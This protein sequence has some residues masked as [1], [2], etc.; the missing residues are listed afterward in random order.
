VLAAGLVPPVVRLSLSPPELDRALMLR[1]LVFAAPMIAFVF[2]QYGMRAVDIV[3]L[4][5]YEP[6]HEVG[7]YAVAYQSYLMLMQVATSATIVLTPLFV[8]LRGAGRT[9]ALA[10]YFRRTVPLLSLAWTVIVAI[11]LPLAPLA[12]PVVFGEDFARASDPIVLLS[13]ALVVQAIASLLA[14]ILVLGERSRD[15]AVINVVAMVVNLAADVLLVGVLRVGIIGPAIATAVS[16]GLIAF[17]YQVVAG[18][19]VD[20]RSQPTPWI[21]APLTVSLLATFLLSGAESVVVGIAGVLV[22]TWG[23][24]RFTSAVQPGD[25]DLIRALRLPGRVELCLVRVAGPRSR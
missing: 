13:L 12:V 19:C 4:R 25:A 22:T 15:I 6:P 20:A 16:V 1:M 17:G 9:E 18:R 23:L 11:A 14:P 8:S 24:L 3:V 21:A 5:A 10:T 7:I 2:S